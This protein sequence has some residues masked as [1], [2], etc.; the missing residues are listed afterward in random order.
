MS[1]LMEPFLN[2][3]DLTSPLHFNQH[4]ILK[5][6]ESARRHT[7]FTSAYK[8]VLFENQTEF[9]GPVFTNLGLEWQSR[10]V[11]EK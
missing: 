5:P 9:L 1:G 4:F 6:I 8:M 3:P 7:S 2:T 11:S 10:A